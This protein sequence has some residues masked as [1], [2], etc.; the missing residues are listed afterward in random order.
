M[1]VSFDL[2][3]LVS[4][5]APTLD[6][7][8]HDPVDWDGWLTPEALHETNPSQLLLQHIPQLHSERPEVSLQSDENLQTMQS[9]NSTKEP[10]TTNL[11]TPSPGVYTSVKCES[12]ENP[13]LLNRESEQLKSPKP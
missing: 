8:D 7:P 2:E 1:M 6:V 4:Y 5:E 9:L 11:R 13:P 12:T 10:M 3:T